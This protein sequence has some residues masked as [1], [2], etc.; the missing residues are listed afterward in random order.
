MGMTADSFLCLGPHGFDRVAYYE[1]GNPKNQHRVI[2]VHGLTRNGRDF[3][4]LAQSLSSDCRVVCPD[5]VGRGNSDWLKNAED[6]GYPLYVSNM[7][8]LIARITAPHPGSLLRGILRGGDNK[9]DWVGTSMGGLIGMMLAAQPNAPIRKLV[10]NDVGPFIPAAALKRLSTYVGNDPS[11]ASL[12]E[13]EADLRKVSAPFGPLTDSQWRHLARHSAE[14]TGDGSYRYSY[15]P[16]I[17][18]PFRAG[19]LKDVDLWPVYDAVTCPT[20]VLR[21]TESDVLL[22]ETASQMNTRGPKAKSIEVKGVGHAPMLMS[23]DQIKIVRDFLLAP[24]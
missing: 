10:L 21:G 23:E 1:W 17:G 11:F 6:Y 19:E 7:A 20:L 8:A 5:V 18:A 14:R 2:C 15:D 9:I 12:E 16:A 13:L 22:P 24:G 3:D 4:F